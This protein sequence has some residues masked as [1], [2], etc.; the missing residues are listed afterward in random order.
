MTGLVASNRQRYSE[1]KSEGPVL[2]QKKLRGHNQMHVQNVISS[3]IGGSSYK[4]ILGGNGVNLSMY[5]IAGFRGICVN[6]LGC[7]HGYMR[8]GCFS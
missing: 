5:W 1:N 6:F 3:C 8:E 2:R 7:G 4:V